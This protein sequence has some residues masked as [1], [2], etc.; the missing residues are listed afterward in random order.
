MPAWQESLYRVYVPYTSALIAEVSGD[1][2][3]EQRRSMHEQIVRLPPDRPW[4]AVIDEA[5][6]IVYVRST[7]GVPEALIQLW[8]RHPSMLVPDAPGHRHPSRDMSLDEL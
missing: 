6:A 1:L 3:P 7:E 5:T 8:R 4:I 2:T